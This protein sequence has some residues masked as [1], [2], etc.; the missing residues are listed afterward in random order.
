VAPLE[1]KLKCSQPSVS[2]GFTS[3]NSTMDRNIQEKN[4]ICI[5]HVIPSF[6]PPFFLALWLE[7]RPQHPG[8]DSLNSDTQA[9]SSQCCHSPRGSGCLTIQANGRPQCC[10]Y[11]TGIRRQELRGSW[12]LPPRFPRKMWKAR[13]CVTVLESV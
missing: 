2:M 10:P 8:S 13:Q 5:E 7:L 9:L 12:G 6:L 4:C 1:F 3:V 11:D